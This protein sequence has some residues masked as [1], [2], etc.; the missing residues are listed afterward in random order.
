M[1]GDPR[2][3]HWSAAYAEGDEHRS[4]TET[5]PRRSLELIGTVTSSKAAAV[6]DVGGGSSGLAGALLA[7][8][9]ADVTVLDIAP[10]AL[11]LA[12]RRLGPEADRVD[13][14]AADLLDWRPERRYAIW[15]DRAVLHFFVADAD[16][17]RYAE[18]VRAALPPG[19]HAVIATFAPDGPAS[20]S[21]LAVRHST[22]DEILEL[23]GD[24]FAAVHHLVAEHRTPSGARQPFAWLVARQMT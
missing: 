11:E 21:G 5:F 10:T 12:Q 15:H 17:R 19:G 1:S 2:R 24:G 6:I 8:G 9:Y 13:W 3:A 7:A 22:A 20:C 16:R 4:W 23:L 18:T 14:L